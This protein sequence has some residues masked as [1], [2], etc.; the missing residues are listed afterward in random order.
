MLREL[1]SQLILPVCRYEDGA[2]CH[3]VI[4]K[5]ENNYVN[6]LY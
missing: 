4:A 1:D 2:K 6:A 5:I 3:A